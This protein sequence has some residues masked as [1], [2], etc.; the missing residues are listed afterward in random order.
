MSSWIMTDRAQLYSEIGAKGIDGTRIQS[1]IQTWE[2]CQA[3]FSEK[4][5]NV[6]RRYSLDYAI[7]VMDIQMEEKEHDALADAY[8]TAL[9]YQK[10]RREKTLQLNKYYV[11]VFRNEVPDRL[12]YSVGEVLKGIKLYA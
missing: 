10:M 8:N 6:H 5:D 12:Q 4:M 11:R 7:K 1:V 9:L 3:I 2:D